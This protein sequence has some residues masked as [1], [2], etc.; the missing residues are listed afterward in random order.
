M[1]F[2]EVG[3][4]PARDAR[5]YAEGWQSW[6][7]TTWYRA[8]Q[9]P[10]RPDLPWQ[11]IMRFRPGAPLP[12]EGSVQGEGLLVVETPEGA[13]WFGAATADQDVATLRASWDGGRVVVASDGPVEHGRADGDGVAALVAWGDAF[14]ARAGARVPPLTAPRVWCSWYQYFEEVT[15]EDIVENVAALD[16]HGLPVEVVQ[17]DDGWSRGLGWALEAA[18]GFGSLDDAVARI[19]DSGRRAGIWLAPFLVGADTDLAR[20]HPGWLVGDAGRNW[21][22]DLRGLDLT[23]PGVREYLSG[24]V[25]ALRDRGFDFFKLDFLYAGALPGE[26]HDGAT[27]VAAYRSGLSL[28][29]EATGEDAFLL[30]CGAPILPSVGLVDGMRV[31]PDT[32]HEG[33]EDG[34][35]GLR[36]RMALAARAWQHGRFWANDSDCLVARPSFR[37]RE[38]W[39]GVVAEFGG[40]R[41]VSDRIAALD[42]WGLA[43]TRRLLEAPPSDGP[44][45]DATVR[46]GA[47]IAAGWE[48]AR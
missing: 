18:P 30:G 12:P 35:T 17:I 11:H 31:S 16:A 21:N 43:A 5:I 4:L 27:P 1:T 34:S 23:H 15:A 28:I 8:G 36:G 33:G 14:G 41:T 20:Q 25:R 9:E 40:L 39:A 22:Q 46:R 24:A 6:S 29:R 26:R 7:P 42:A 48:E 47:A 38:E 32:F 3:D 45:P 37:L 44:L 10:H 13:W 2:V 19:H